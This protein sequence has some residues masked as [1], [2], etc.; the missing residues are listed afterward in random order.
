MKFIYARITIVMGMQ[1]R[2]TRK[3][4]KALTENLWV[5]CRMMFLSIR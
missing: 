5:E 3:H 4:K 1:K 2:S